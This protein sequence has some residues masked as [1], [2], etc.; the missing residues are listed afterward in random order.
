MTQSPSSSARRYEQTLDLQVPRE[1]VWKAL[2][3]G[4]EIARWFA[5][6]A[7]VDPQVGGVVG[8]TWRDHF[9][10]Q[11]TIDVFEPGRHLR[12]RYDAWRGEG[13]AAHPLFIDFHLE[14]DGG[15]TTLRIVHSGF[16]ADASFDQEFDA[17]SGGWPIELASLRLYLERHLGRER[18][19]TW[20]RAVVDAPQDEVWRQLSAA[21]A[22]GCA[23]VM[24]HANGDAFSFTTGDGDAFEGTVLK[25]EGTEFVGTAANHGDGWLRAWVGAHDGRTMLWLWLATYG[26]GPVAG[27]QQRWDALVERLFGE[28]LVRSDA[29]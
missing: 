9:D 7:R 17:I 5:P 16:G 22:F 24:Q 23:A 28:R 2:T 15:A 18:H 26:H 25:A 3:D 1:A 19:L 29:S 21:D 11:Q 20:T 4:A 13:D 8:W 27:L 10:W 6:E 14:G 12:T